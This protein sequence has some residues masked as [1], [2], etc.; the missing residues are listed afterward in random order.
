MFSRATKGENT[1]FDCVADAEKN[2]SFSSPL[3]S[4]QFRWHEIHA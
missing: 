3:I 4:C 1:R 2:E